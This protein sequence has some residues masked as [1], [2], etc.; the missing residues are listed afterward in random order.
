MRSVY[1]D[2]VIQS[3]DIQTNRMVGEI[4]NLIE[5]S[6]LDSPST[7]ALKKSIKQTMWRTNRT[8]QDDVNSLSFTNE[9]K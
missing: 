1:V 9:D 8:I 7:I 5:A 3:L 6:L 4:M 2:G